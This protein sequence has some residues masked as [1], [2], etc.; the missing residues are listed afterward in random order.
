MTGKNTNLLSRRWG[1]YFLLG[2]I[3]LTLELEAEPGTP[4]AEVTDLCGA[5]TRCLEACPTGALPEPYR[6]DSNRCISYWTIEHRDDLPTEAREMV[7]EWVFGCD[8]CQEVWPWNDRPRSGLPEAGRE[9][10]LRL[11]AERRS[12]DLTGLLGLDRDGYVERFQ[13]SPMKRVKLEGLRRNAAVAMGN[14]GDPRYVPALAEALADDS[15]MVRRH[16]ASALGRIAAA[17]D[18]EALQAL[19]DAGNHERDPGV[20]SEISEACDRAACHGPGGRQNC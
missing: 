3:L 10:L 11:P 1:S 4:A 20:A 5:C 19:R 9:P 15:A 7:G 8:I 18:R 13:V 16:A 17:G 14:R 12:L 6:L 2:E